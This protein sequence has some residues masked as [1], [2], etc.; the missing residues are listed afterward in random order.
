VLVACRGD[1]F[2]CERRV[3]CPCRAD[4]A[5]SRFTSSSHSRRMVAS[6][7]HTTPPR[8]QC[9]GT[10]TP[11]Q[12]RTHT[13]ARYGSSSSSGS[14]ANDPAG[15]PKVGSRGGRRRI[16]FR[17]NEGSATR[18]GR[19][20]RPATRRSVD[21]SDLAFGSKAGIE[22]AFEW[23]DQARGG[24]GAGAVGRDQPGRIRGAACAIGVSVTSSVLMTTSK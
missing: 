23:W 24:N 15:L 4:A 18:P 3:D 14:T 19:L 1:A 17:R 7:L 8:W 13:R 12:A 21:S 6:P 2:E 10:G 16:P 5:A 20:R 9:R 22:P 11:D